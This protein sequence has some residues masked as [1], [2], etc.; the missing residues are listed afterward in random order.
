MVF[1]KHKL[2]NKDKKVAFQQGVID[3]NSNPNQRYRIN[4]NDRNVGED[5]FPHG[6]SKL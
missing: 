3:T 1:K 4:A 6:L 5:R 2:L